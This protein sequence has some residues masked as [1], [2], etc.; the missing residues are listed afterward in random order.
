MGDGNNKQNEVSAMT[1]TTLSHAAPEGFIQAQDACQ[2]EVL[3]DFFDGPSEEGDG[4]KIYTT[5]TVERGVTFEL[6]T[7]DGS[8]ITMLTASQAL[9]AGNALAM[10]AAK[11]AGPSM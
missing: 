10:L 9:A 5:F 2:P 6:L 4:W 3:A 1:T 11:Y 8:V 7:H